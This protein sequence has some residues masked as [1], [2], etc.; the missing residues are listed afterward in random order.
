MFLQKNEDWKKTGSVAGT[1][2]INQIDV[3]LIYPG[4]YGFSFFLL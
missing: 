3:L 1:N 2:N 4:L